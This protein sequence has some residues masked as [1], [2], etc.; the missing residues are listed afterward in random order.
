MIS[1]VI[2]NCNTSK[3]LCDC[4]KSAQKHCPEAEIIVVDNASRDDSVR[5]VLHDFK[6]VTLVQLPE[7]RGSAGATN[8]GLRQA[9]GEFLVLLNSD[10][11]LEDDSLTRCANWMDE[12]PRIGACGPR[13]IDMDGHPQPCRYRFPRLSSHVREAL[14]MKPKPA[15]A[16]ETEDGW[17][18][19]TALMIRREALEELGGRLDDAYWMYWED[20]DFSAR[21]REKGWRTAEFADGHVRHCRGARDGGPDAVNRPDLYAWYAWGRLRW[22]HLYRPFWEAATLWCLELADVGRKFLR[23]LLR[24]ARRAEWIHA[25]ALLGVLARRLVGMR[26]RVPGA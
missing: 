21:L 2:V 15:G 10:T 23:G 22:F 16:L 18:A 6:N 17:I 20:A 11:I 9:S 4:L 24:P 19:G 25:R 26:P 13:L 3:L 5:M 12:N 8:L 1:I 14:R 7:N